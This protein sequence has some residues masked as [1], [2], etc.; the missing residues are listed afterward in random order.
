MKKNQ[1]VKL[2]NVLFPLWMVML[3]PLAWLVVLPGNFVIDSIVLIIGM[4]LFKVSEKKQFYKK[5]IL[6]I[7]AFGM[8]SDI[9]GA[10]FML[11]CFVV[12]SLGRMGDEWYI[13][14]PAII[15][16]AALIFIFNYFITFKKEEKPLRL[17]MALLFT[18]VT[19]PYTFLVPSGWLY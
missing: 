19:A 7:F 4:F 16:S 6:K 15:I 3:F 9:V 5:H 12:L 1:D 10:G 18:I 11:L 8:V 2:Y 13:T 14:V 17:K